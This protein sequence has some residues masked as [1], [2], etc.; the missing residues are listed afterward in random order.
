MLNGFKILIFALDGENYAIDIQ[1]IERILGYE[2]PTKLP[3]N[4]DFVKGV[5][6]YENS[7]LPVI[8]LPVKFGFKESEDRELEKI[9]VVKRETEKFGII[10]DNVHE[11]R[12]VNENAL[13]KNTYISNV[14]KRKYIKGLIRLEEKIIIVLNI[15]EILSDEEAKEIF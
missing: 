9:I 1:D 14:I 4:P 11:V 5:I 13:E 8:S 12:D 6:D 3:E 15:E 10:V 2:E 7:I